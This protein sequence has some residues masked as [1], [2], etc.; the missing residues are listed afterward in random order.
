MDYKISMGMRMISHK[1]IMSTV[2]NISKQNLQDPNE[3]ANGLF[4]E[5]MSKKCLFCA[6]NSPNAAT[7]CMG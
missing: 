2:A 5:T 3:S 1:W 6:F 7:A 4:Q